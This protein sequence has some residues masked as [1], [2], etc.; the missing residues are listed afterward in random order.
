MVLLG[1]LAAIQSQDCL[2]TDPRFLWRWGG[3]NLPLLCEASQG[4]SW[5]VQKVSRE[6]GVSGC[7]FWIHHRFSGLFYNMFLFLQTQTVIVLTSESF[8]ERVIMKESSGQLP[9]AES[10][11]Y[12]LG[13]DY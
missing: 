4:K 2:M 13:D 1:H 9:A 10:C 3:P 12:W 5:M 6:A 8:I 7:Y 11:Q